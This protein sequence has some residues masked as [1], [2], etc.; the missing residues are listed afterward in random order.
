MS[1]TSTIT[2]ACALC[3][4]AARELYLAPALAAISTCVDTLVVND[5]SGQPH[6]EN[7]AKL[8][9]SAF[10]REGRLRVYDHAFIDF[11]DMRNR[12]YA[13]L[14]EL[15]PR[16][17]WVLFLDADEVHGA[18]L[19]Y[20]AREILPRLG[21]EIGSVDA[22]TYHFW[23]TF[24]WIT[25]IARRFVFFRYAPDVRWQNAVHE[26][27]VGVRGRSLVLP[28]AYHHYGNVVPPATLAEKWGRYYDLGNDVPPPPTPDA[29]TREVYLTRA[30]DVRPYRAP[31]PAVARE[32]LAAIATAFAPEFALLDA[33]L[34]A[35]RTRA[36]RVAA[37][38]RGSNETLRVELRRA[39]HPGRYRERTTAR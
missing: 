23:G 22:Y 19:R 1:K 8:E 9:A 38:L 18:Q 29:V 13:H 12:A 14:A 35:R 16:P 24:G 6:G 32:T 17:D 33:G 3:V 27:A 21:A 39:E 36:M 37:N 2:I 30:A 4:G 34:V 11:A 28:Y 31:H 7:R 10:G 15:D 26:R 20:I 5:N 25:D